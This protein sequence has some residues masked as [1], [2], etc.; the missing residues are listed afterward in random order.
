M[1]HL[2]QQIYFRNLLDTDDVSTYFYNQPTTFASRNPV[3]VPEEGNGL[4]FV[5]PAELHE[6][7]D[8]TCDGDGKH[9]HACRNA[10]SR[11]GLT[12]PNADQGRQVNA[13]LWLIVD[14]DQPETANFLDQARAVLVGVLSFYEPSGAH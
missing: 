13:S 7:Q 9:E 3:I 6:M 5:N 2:M 8:F 1:Q 10:A 4:Q 14:V 11:C 12:Y